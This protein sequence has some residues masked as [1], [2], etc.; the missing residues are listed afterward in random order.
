[1]RA[2]CNNH[3]EQWRQATFDP[4]M[5]KGGGESFGPRIGFSYLKFEALKQSVPAVRLLAHLLTSIGWRHHLWCIHSY[6]CKL[7]FEIKAVTFWQ[8]LFQFLLLD[9]ILNYIP[10]WGC[11]HVFC[12]NFNKICCHFETSKRAAKM[13]DMLW[14][15]YCHRQHFLIETWLLSMLRK[16]IS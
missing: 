9:S 10:I 1:M 5:S 2:T 7:R 13:A 15:D 6:L 16:V 14:S 11:I 4:R 12:T 8:N 3:R